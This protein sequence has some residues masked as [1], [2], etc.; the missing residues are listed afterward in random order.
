MTID[1]HSHTTASDGSLEPRQL[2]DRAANQGVEMLSITDHD[3]IE[4]YEH[5][6]PYAELPLTLVPGIELSTVWQGT[7][8]HVLA[9]NIR[10]DSDAMLVAVSEQDRA[11]S[12]RAKLIG[13]RLEKLGIKDALGGA[14]RLAGKGWIG[15]PHFAQYLVDTGVVPD[16]RRAFRKYLG[17]GKAGDVKHLWPPLEQIIEWARDAGGTTVLAHPGRYGL[18]RSKLSRLLR[19]FVAAGGQGMEVV[20]GR[21][22]H[23]EIKQL[24]VLCRN[25][26]LLASCGS[27]FHRPGRPWSELG[28]IPPIPSGCRPVWEHW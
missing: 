18:T 23:E 8:I 4:A 12:K 5:L 20:S 16:Q 24:A 7:A 27:D 22:Q 13:D 25:N 21:Q 1:L 19:G 6:Q 15:R 14:L 28:Q 3:S 2:I 11:R 26:D 9:L 17:S 10:L